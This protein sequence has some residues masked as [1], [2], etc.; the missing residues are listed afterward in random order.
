MKETRVGIIGYGAMG[1]HHANVWSGI[2][3]VW[4]AA[5][6]DP[7]EE[8]RREAKAKWGCNVF[9]SMEGMF[10]FEKSA[11]DVVIVATHVPMHHTQVLSAIRHGCHVV[12]EKPMAAT[13]QECDDMVA[14]ARNADVRLA[15]HHQSI[16]SR[17]FRDARDR[18][19]SHEIGDLQVMRAY[20]KGRIACSDLM[21]IA[22]HLTHGMCYLAGADP[23]RV[24]GDVTSQGRDVTFKDVAR[25]QDL[26]PAGRDS[27]MGAGDRMFGF[28][29]FANGARG[30]LQLTMVDDPPSTFNEQRVCGYYI[31]VFGTAER[32]RLYLPRVLFRNKSPL[33]D[34]ARQET[35]WD[36]VNP[37]YRNDKDPVLTS[38]FA[39]DFLC[40]IAEKRDPMVPGSDG[41][42]VMET[43]LGIY[44]AHLLGSSL[45]IPLTARAHP[46]IYHA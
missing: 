19:A 15:I 1:Q 40:A 33:D 36:E 3:D 10:K 20:G 5:V 21:E 18:I 27:G 37:D 6:V 12:C 11:L 28:Y 26:Y 4:V 8:L 44:R 38:Y 17:A 34:Q 31:D 39:D 30:E 16:F 32:L 42:K 23:I 7:V 13:L 22:G 35:P 46:F 24:W 43:T 41:V 45:P 29:K 14:M 2:P 9:K 25:V